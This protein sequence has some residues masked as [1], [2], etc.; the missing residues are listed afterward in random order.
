MESKFHTR[1][2]NRNFIRSKNFDIYIYIYI[3]KY[4]Y[5]YI[6]IYMYIIYI[7]IR[8]NPFKTE[9][10][11][12]KDTFSLISVKKYFFSTTIFGETMCSKSVNLVWWK[13]EERKRERK[14][15]R[16]EG[17]K[18]GKYLTLDR[19]RVVLA[20]YDRARSG[21]RSCLYVRVL[22]NFEKILWQV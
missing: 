13:E 7:Y 20:R 22:E 4:K 12:G 11:D 15:E 9:I 18:K 16:K 1:E 21:E 2:R 6:Y 10:F 3:H 8:N 14:K 5:I 19:E 17:R